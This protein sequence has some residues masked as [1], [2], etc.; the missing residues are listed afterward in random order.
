MAWETGTANG[1]RDLLLKL[2]S[3]SQANG[4]KVE[5]WVYDPLGLGS[6]EL[7]VS[8]NGP[9]EQEYFICGF[10]TQSSVAA[11]CYNWQLVAGPLFSGGSEFDSQPNSTAIQ[12]MY[13]WQNELRYWF[14]I[15]KARIVVVAQVSGTTHVIYNGKIQNYCSLGHWPRQVGCY[16]EGVNAN[17]RWSSQGDEYSTFQWIRNAAQQTLWIDSSFITPS[18][19]YP[20][21]SVSGLC[22]NGWTYSEGAHWLIPM[23]LLHHEHGAIGEF[24]GCYYIDGHDTS[25]LQTI[26]SLDGL[27][28]LLVVQNIYRNGYRDFM[29]LELA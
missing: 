3:F 29:A 17:G 16:G 2:K 1:H 21:M 19:V 11:D 22:R 9:S 27:N 26:N 14:V 10:K 4:W 6:D 5:R 13:L 25:S 15:D 18:M 8:S 23:T 24:I 7:I 12:Y 28:T 20:N